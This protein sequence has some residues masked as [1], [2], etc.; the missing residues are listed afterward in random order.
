[1]PRVKAPDGNVINF[2]DSMSNDEISMAMQRLYP[3]AAD[4]PSTGFASKKRG[5]QGRGS[6][7]QAA[8][9]AA[10]QSIA[11]RQKSDRGYV[12]KATIGNAMI[13]FY[14]DIEAGAAS[15]PT[16]IGN[17]VKRL[18]GQDPKFSGD[19]YQRQFKK[20]AQ[21]LRRKEYERAPI[22]GTIQN[23][24][25][26]AAS[27]IIPIST[28]TKAVRGAKGLSAVTAAAKP[29]L[30]GGAV[31]AAYGAGQ[32]D[33]LRERGQNALTGGATA[34]AL[35]AGLSGLAAGAGRVLKKRPKPLTPRQQDIKTLQD[36][37][38]DLT[39]GQ[40]LGGTAKQFEE[41]GSRI[42]GGIR[43][44][45]NAQLDQFSTGVVNKVLKII[46]KKLPSG[47]QRPTEEIAAMQDMVGKYY[48]DAYSSGKFIPD[49]VTSKRL[50]VMLEDAMGGASVKSI[51]EAKRLSNIYAGDAIK[52]KGGL[53]GKDLTRSLNQINTRI[54]S[55][56]SSQNGDAY[57]AD[58]LDGLK[59]EIINTMIRNKT[60][61]ARRIAKANRAYAE[62]VRV[63]GA[64]GSTANVGTVTPTSLLGSVKKYTG[65]QRKRA[66]SSGRG[67]GQ[68]Y[69]MAAKNILADTTKSSGTAENSANI[70]TY[71]SAPIGLF[72]G[73]ALALAPLALK[74]VL[75]GAY[76]P[77]VI[78]LLNRIAK[79]KTQQQANSGLLALQS[80][81]RTNPQAA[82]ALRQLLA[83]QGSRV[84]TM[85]TGQMSQAA[86]QEEE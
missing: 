49:N 6:A 85:P 82:K 15:L 86:A 9:K 68:Q 79:A 74:G 67:L 50:E 59:R 39:Y 7:E 8:K 11:F 54:R 43:N 71:T 51:N 44:A 29:V 45:R 13:P 80:A 17:A 25:G 70:I 16:R 52:R 78:S 5:F 10:A 1:M 18:Q 33:T 41:Y 19:Q 35:G 72:T 62:M 57:L 34:L 63:E 32:G 46:D 55:E 75:R 40:I 20:Q 2:P 36:A 65:G 31:G 56:R 47:I 4:R 27:A 28:S 38:L 58:Y 81:A 23:I 64:A 69:A 53:E 84:N 48:G 26:G 83:V 21:E 3:P 30:A 37:G 66:F 22:K 42:S 61:D 14:G 77:P 12:D 24:A 76:S 60:V 73:N